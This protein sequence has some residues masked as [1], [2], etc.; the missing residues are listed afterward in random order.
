MHNPSFSTSRC[1]LFVSQEYPWLAATPD[2]LVEDDGGEV[3]SK[4][5]LEIKNPYKQR[6]M[7]LKEACKTKPFC[8]KKDGDT[9]KLNQKHDY[10][11]QVQC[12]LFYVNR[13]WC[14]FVERTQ[15]EMHTE[16][17][18]RE[19]EWWDQQL[20]KLEHFYFQAVLPEL[21]CPRHF[22]GGIREP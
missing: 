15:K 8:L 6:N 19:R 14:D 1:G 2:G 4:G 20:T 16:R 7:T 10:Y 3:S 11:Y 22:K 17:I 18:Y 9:Y 21:A 12:Q 5:L 13:D